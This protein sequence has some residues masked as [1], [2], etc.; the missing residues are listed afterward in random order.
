MRSKIGCPDCR[1]LRHRYNINK[2]YNNM[3]EF[4]CK[5]QTNPEDRSKDNYYFIGYFCSIKKGETIYCNYF[6][7]DILKATKHILRETLYVKIYL[8][9]KLKLEMRKIKKY[10][11]KELIKKYGK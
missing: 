6:K 1:N 5:K 4:D 8:K 7:W 10:S 3:N 11:K 9:L 2:H